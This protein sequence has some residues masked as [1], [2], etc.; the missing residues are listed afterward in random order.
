MKVISQKDKIFQNIYPIAKE[1]SHK[2][3]IWVYLEDKEVHTHTQE[4]GSHNKAEITK[5]SNQA[6]Y[7]QDEAATVYA[8]HREF[9]SR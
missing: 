9:A 5:Y 3:S 4:D 2:F 8:M 6:L 1:H 7:Y